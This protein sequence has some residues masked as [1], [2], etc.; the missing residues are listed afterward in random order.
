[1]ANLLYK[2][3]LLGTLCLAATAAAEPY[4]CRKDEA[5]ATIDVIHERP[6]GEL[7]CRV[8]F[9]PPSGEPQTLW[10]VQ[11][12]RGFC[13]KKAAKKRD[14]LEAQGWRCNME[15]DT[16]AAP[17]DE[18]CRSE[19]AAKASLCSTL[20][21]KLAD[22]AASEGLERLL[23]DTRPDDV[24]VL[25]LAESVSLALRNSRDVESGYLGRVRDQLA[26]EV[27]ED[28]FWPDLTI[29]GGPTWTDEGGM[30]GTLSSTVGLR[31]PTG[32]E[33]SLGWANEGNEDAGT[34][35]LFGD[36]IQPLWGGAGVDANLAN[37]RQARLADQAGDLAF[38]GRVIDLVTE[39]IVSHR[40]LTIAEASLQVAV[41]SLDR[42]IEQKRINQRLLEA[43]RIPRF[44]AVQSDANIASREVDL[45]SSKL[46]LEDARRRLL[47][48]LDIDSRATLMVED[49]AMPS[50]IT[51]AHDDAL[52][53]AL[54]FR[55]DFRT[56]EIDGQA[57]K[58]NLASARSQSR[59]EIDLVAG[60]DHDRPLYSNG[61]FTAGSETSYRAGFRLNIPFGDV[62]RDQAE[63][64]AKLNIRE[65]DIVLKEAESS[66]T[67]EI[68]NLIANLDTTRQ[69]VALAE[70]AEALAKQQLAAEQTK[71]TRG[72]S[73]TLD[74]ITLEDALIDAQLGTLDARVAY[75]NTLT[76]LDRAMGTTL[77]TWGINLQR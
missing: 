6:K 33:L 24:V 20:D 15:E 35:R 8:V 7:P 72:L 25:S 32:G 48:L 77:M 38:R 69:R 36:V 19:N 44:E 43:G 13:A 3:T 11:H 53:L 64:L 46:D 58:F 30:S 9:S 28:E 54:R 71:Y 23:S 63:R 59:S 40:G 41:R 39:V 26:L 70:R 55:P 76:E 1:M 34:S 74:V 65:S 60:I 16:V 31:L 67:I 5:V 66:I 51:L 27:A 56:A 68:A 37:L 21:S 10:R 45:A 52:D 17:I 57:A 47:N 2:V 75:A 61:T 42:A 4:Q 12:E 22:D 29:E 73:S 50:D 18:R 49:V 62:A 14:L